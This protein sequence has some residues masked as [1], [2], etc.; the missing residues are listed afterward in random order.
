[1]RE[2]GAR[3]LV[4]GRVEMA[5]YPG[6]MPDYSAFLETVFEAGAYRVYAIPEYRTVS[7]R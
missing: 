6:L 7:T 2:F 5:N 1:M 3:Y 4:A